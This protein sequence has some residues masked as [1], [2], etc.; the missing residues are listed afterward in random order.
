MYK[1]FI[2]AYPQFSINQIL[3]TD[4][5]HETMPKPIVYHKRT[6]MM[7]NTAYPAL[8]LI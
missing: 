6:A 7:V 5:D 2:I 3:I 8:I 4:K 1:G